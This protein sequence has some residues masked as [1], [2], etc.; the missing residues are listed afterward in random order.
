[1]IALMDN[2]QDFVALA[3]LFI[4]AATA[5]HSLLFVAIYD[6]LKPFKTA[7]A[8]NVILFSNQMIVSTE[9]S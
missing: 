8:F 2:T 4:T 7:I 6:F 3:F 5:C 1:M 9:D